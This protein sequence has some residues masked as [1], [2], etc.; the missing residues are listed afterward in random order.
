MYQQDGRTLVVFQ[1]CM[2]TVLLELC[3]TGGQEHLQ[4]DIKAMPGQYIVSP[5]SGGSQY[6]PCLR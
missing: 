5:I 3:L 2:Q 6:V 4:A 1:A